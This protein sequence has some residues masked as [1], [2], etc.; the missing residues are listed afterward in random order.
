MTE[1]NVLPADENYSI[2][3]MTPGQLDEKGQPLPMC[4]MVPV[5]QEVLEIPADDTLQIAEVPGDIVLLE[6]VDVVEAPVT[7]IVEDSG[8]ISN[9]G[10]TKMLPEIGTETLVMPPETGTIEEEA[11]VI[12]DGSGINETGGALS[13]SEFEP[14][15]RR[16]KNLPA[17]LTAV[18][19]VKT[20]LPLSTIH[21]LT[22]T[23]SGAKLPNRLSLP[24]ATLSASSIVILT[25]S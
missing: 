17:L 19:A 9:G 15:N 2:C 25:T 16:L 5:T 18:R 22:S 13:A 21:G 23:Q 6:T 1:Q 24:A 8:V 10:I 12:I 11:G 3:A 14:E 4:Q 7:E 20:R